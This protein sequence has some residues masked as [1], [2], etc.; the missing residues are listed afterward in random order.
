MNGAALSGIGGL[1]KPEDASHEQGSPS[2]RT[3]RRWRAKELH[4]RRASAS[5]QGDVETQRGAQESGGT[6]WE[7]ATHEEPR[8]AGERQALRLRLNRRSI[9][10]IMKTCPRCGFSSLYVHECPGCFCN[11]VPAPARRKGGVREQRAGSAAP[12]AEYCATVEEAY[13]AGWERPYEGGTVAT[14]F[15]GRIYGQKPG[16]HRVFRCT[17]RQS[18]ALSGSAGR[19]GA[20]Q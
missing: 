16:N 4:A 12:E 14:G 11:L 15:K 9:N 5:P 20:S 1:Q 13:N 2:S 8:Q 10:G 18:D 3:A 6:G 17:K 19:K 7:K